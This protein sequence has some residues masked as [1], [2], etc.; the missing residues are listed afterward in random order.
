MIS[1]IKYYKNGGIFMANSKMI[2][3]EGAQGT[4]KTTVTDYIRHSIKYTNLYRL[5][6][7][8][9]S[10]KEGKKKAQAMYDALM[11]YIEKMQK[12][13]QV[14]VD[15]EI[16]QKRNSNKRLMAYA[17]ASAELKQ[18]QR[19]DKMSKRKDWVQEE[20]NL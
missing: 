10:T 18:K 6:G 7:T 1:Y 20:I 15:Y 4:G 14:N 3:V 2:I 17:K 16:E 5:S 13:K 9:D 19:L 11:D 12:E 8:S